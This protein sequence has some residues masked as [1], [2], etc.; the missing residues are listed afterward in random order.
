LKAADETGI[1]QISI[2]GY[3][4]EWNLLLAACSTLPT[5]EISA[6]I[7]ALTQNPI[8]WNDLF[9]VA[10]RHG[11]TCLV[12]QAL[13][14]VRDAVPSREMSTV[15]QRYEANLLKVLLTARELIRILDAL[16][17][18]ALEVMPYKGLA[19]AETL[20][21]DVAARQAG[22]ID[23]L[24]HARDFTRVK[25]A[26]HDLGY[27]THLKLSAKE[28]HAYLISGYE[29]SFDS[30]AGKNLLEV[31][32]ALQPRFYAVDFDIEGVFR[33]AVPVTVTGREMKTPSPEDLVLVLSLHAAKHLWTRLIWIC[34]IARLMQLP[35]L[36]WNWI[37]SQARA[38][39]IVRIL[40][41]TLLLAQQLLK[42]AIPAAIENDIRNDHEAQAWSQS[43]G[44]TIVS[45]GSVDAESWRYFRMMM[46]LRERPRDRVCLLW[47]LAL[48]PGP[49][50]WESVRL[51]A[52]LFPLY[53]IVRLWRLA[54]RLSR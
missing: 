18:L 37:S 17:S 15:Q 9:S 35:A 7:R 34:D 20:Y 26:V 43:I 42:A 49:S 51:P 6:R 40:R 44:E 53:R 1:A 16:D 5:P 22:D 41:V 36:N 31:Q 19:L 54:A 46:S 25:D 32:W 29:C 8:R 12:Y 23:L 48:T 10:E 39:G 28:Q 47:R 3:E 24:I 33:R 14:G 50:E 52:S 11:V 2:A 38:L 27:I 45:G 4:S 21:G 30:A 13:S